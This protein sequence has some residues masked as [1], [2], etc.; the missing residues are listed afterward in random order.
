LNNSEEELDRR[1]DMLQQTAD[2]VAV[3]ILRIRKA[4]RE[5][6]LANVRADKT[7]QRL[8]A[9][10]NAKLSFEKRECAKLIEQLS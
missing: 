7:F 2:W 5:K 8:R 10:L 4:V 6:G 9:G 3:D 1:L